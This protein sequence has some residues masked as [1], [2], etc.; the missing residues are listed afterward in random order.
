VEVTVEN[1]VR[2]FGATAALYGVS[3]DIRAG[4]LIAL[5]GPSGSGK[6]PL[7]RILSRP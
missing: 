4:E 7:L 2:T 5:L 1:V 3:L 6:T